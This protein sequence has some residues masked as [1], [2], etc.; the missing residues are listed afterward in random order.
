VLKADIAAK[1]FF[2][3]RFQAELGRLLAALTRRPAGL[4][5]L[6]ARHTGDGHY[7]GQREVAI[8]AI[9]GSENRT[10]DF[11]AHFNPLSETTIERWIGIFR[12]RQKGASLPPVELAQIGETYYVRDGHHRISVA[13]AMDQMY[14]DARIT[15][16]R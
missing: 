13:R 3:L 10:Q 8:E 14:I 2:A 5:P 9:K 16:I 12:A 7:A 4:S 6:P 1:K 11:D 15:Q